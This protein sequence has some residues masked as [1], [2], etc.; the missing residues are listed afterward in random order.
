MD[1]EKDGNVSEDNFK[2]QLLGMYN[3]I[4]NHTDDFSEYR[5]S[6]LELD[7]NSNNYIMDI[8]S[9]LRNGLKY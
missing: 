1:E 4:F 2:K 6:K 3:I 8:L 5:N 9:L 7:R